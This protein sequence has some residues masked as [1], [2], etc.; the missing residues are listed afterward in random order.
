MDGF[1]KP[2]VGVTVVIVIVI[3]V[4]Y[5]VLTKRSARGTGA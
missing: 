2:T 3:L 4:G 5:H 1:H